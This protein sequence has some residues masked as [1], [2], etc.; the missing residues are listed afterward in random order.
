MF[1]SKIAIFFAPASAARTASNGN[2][3]KSLIFTSRALIPCRMSSSTTTR[4]VPVTVPDV[5][6]AMS[7]SAEPRSLPTG[8][9]ST[10]G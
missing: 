2:G 6:S 4:A 1:R 5:T 8:Y 10:I 9:V 7:A 3:R